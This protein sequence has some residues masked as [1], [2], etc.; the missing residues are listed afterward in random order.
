LV[1]GPTKDSQEL[2]WTGTRGGYSEEKIY[3]EG[4]LVGNSRGALRELLGPSIAPRRCKVAVSVA[5]RPPILFPFAAELSMEQGQSEVRIPSH[6]DFPS[7]F[8]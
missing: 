8:V 3:P 6:W 7:G 2:S 5:V 1:I 4:I